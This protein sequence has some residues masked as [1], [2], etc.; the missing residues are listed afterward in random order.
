V[1]PLKFFKEYICKTWYILEI[2][3]TFLWSGCHAWKFGI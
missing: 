3:Y 2:E 1:L